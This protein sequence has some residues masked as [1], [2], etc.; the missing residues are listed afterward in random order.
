M[1]LITKENDRE[2]IL[3]RKLESVE[4]PMFEY[5]TLVVMEEVMRRSG[6]IGL[7]ANQVGIN[8]RM[9][10]FT[11]NGGKVEYAINPKVLKVGKDLM[12]ME[13]S[14][15]SYPG[16]KRV[17]NRPKDIFVAYTTANDRKV[18]KKLY[19]L[20]ARIFLH[21]LDHLNGECKVGK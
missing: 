18:T 4:Y 3:N 11:L 15:L 1:R 16:E 21:E 20:E 5:T 6:G 10:V 13:E 14:C 19:G 7:A 9:F 8:K 2:G 17:I 12:S